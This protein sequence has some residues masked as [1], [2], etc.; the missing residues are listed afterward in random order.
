[1]NFFYPM[2]NNKLLDGLRKSGEKGIKAPTM[3]PSSR[4][5]DSI[6]VKIEKHSQLCRIFRMGD[7]SEKVHTS[8]FTQGSSSYSESSVYMHVCV[9]RCSGLPIPIIGIA[10][11]EFTPLWL[12]ELSSLEASLKKGVKSMQRLRTQ[13]VGLLKILNKGLEI[14]MCARDT[15]FFVCLSCDNFLFGGGGLNL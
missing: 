6:N 7:L 13:E 11:V 3:L 4:N 14:V 15:V 2:L 5:P 10:W 12:P 8:V 1:M 9:K